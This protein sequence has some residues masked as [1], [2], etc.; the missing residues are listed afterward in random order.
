MTGPERTTSIGGIKYLPEQVKSS[1]SDQEFYTDNSGNLKSK[2]IF[3]VELQDGTSLKYEEQAPEREAF[4]IKEEAWTNFFGLKG[5]EISD[6]PNDDNYNLRGCES[7]SVEARREHEEGIIFT[8]YESDDY[9]HIKLEHRKMNDGSVQA[10]TNNE[11]YIKEGA[12][13]VTDNTKNSGG[14]NSIWHW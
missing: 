10:C 14:K 4:V 5:V 13:T 12:D 2:T 6:T 7:C 8:S 1:K 9:D 3:S 11:V